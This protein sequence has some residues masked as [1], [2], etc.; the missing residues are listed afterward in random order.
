MSNPLPPPLAP[1]G[2]FS[3]SSYNQVLSLFSVIVQRRLDASLHT[4]DPK[5]NL[6]KPVFSKPISYTS[7]IGFPW[8]RSD[9]DY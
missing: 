5:E 6:S 2:T 1:T 9:T 8:I 7:L 4:G 3:Q